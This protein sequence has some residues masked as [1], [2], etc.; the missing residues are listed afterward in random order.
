MN[1]S[2]EIAD[3][4]PSKR[5]LDPVDRISEVLFGLIMAL[6]FTGTVSATSADHAEIH[7]MLS[8]ALGCNLA[9]GIVDAVMYLLTELTHRGRNLTLLHVARDTRNPEAA[10]RAIASAIPPRVASVV[11][12]EEL[13][14]IRLRINTL[15]EP[16]R[17]ARLDRDDYLAALGVCLLVF[18]STFPVA[19]PFMIMS[20]P[21]PAMRI[22]N[23]IA[24]VML[25]L[26][27][28]SLGRLAGHR[29]WLVGA[30]LAVLGSALVGLTIALGG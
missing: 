3:L 11:G 19:I 15:P 22:S 9:W 6:G 16:P 20:D 7:T 17:R 5:L 30:M 27:G 2:P 14:A 10:R 29:P 26:C 25:F 13:E 4:A 1:A 28:A 18:L 21:K 12:T 23:L 8:G 24:V